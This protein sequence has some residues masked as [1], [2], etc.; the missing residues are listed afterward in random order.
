[1]DDET[2]LLLRGRGRSNYNTSCTVLL[3]TTVV[4]VAQSVCVCSDNNFRT[5]WRV[6]GGVL[7]IAHRIWEM[8][9]GLAI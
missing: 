3:T 1:M 7:K 8:A 9:S 4:Q 6:T 2:K 5:K